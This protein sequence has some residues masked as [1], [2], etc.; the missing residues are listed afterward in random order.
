MEK[1][2]V[3]ETLFFQVVIVTLKEKKRYIKK[4][5]GRSKLVLCIA[6]ITLREQQ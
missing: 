3:Y 5:Q 1:A 4:I 2:W 6:E